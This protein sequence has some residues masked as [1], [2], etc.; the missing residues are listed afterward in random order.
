MVTRSSANST[1]IDECNS[2]VLA[3]RGHSTDLVIAH[4]GKAFHRV[5]PE[6]EEAEE[7]EEKMH[8]AEMGIVLDIEMTKMELIQGDPLRRRI[9]GPWLGGSA[10]ANNPCV[11][12][13]CFLVVLVHAE[14]RS[15][16]QVALMVEPEHCLAATE[17]AEMA[18]CA[19]NAGIRH[20]QGDWRANALL[21]HM[22]AAAP[23]IRTVI[24]TKAK[25]KR[26]NG[27]DNGGGLSVCGNLL[28]NYNLR[29]FRDTLFGLPTT[30]CCSL[31]LL[32]DSFTASSFLVPTTC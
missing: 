26:T 24:M 15:M 9:S 8:A 30:L 1:I 25:R 10:L 11:E 12:L 27:N 5:A 28:M 21:S 17:P 14:G 6:Y 16:L 23:A 19:Q 32:A 2:E 31:A 4:Q 18:E 20:E 7:V 29:K 13:C 22:M 3:K